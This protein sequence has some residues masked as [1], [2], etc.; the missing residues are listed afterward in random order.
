M[1]LNAD[2]NIQNKDGKTASFMAAQQG[3]AHVLKKLKSK[4]NFQ[5]AE[6]IEG[7]TPL[8][9]AALG[10]HSECVRELISAGVDVSSLNL[11]G[12]TALQVAEESKNHDVAN[13]LFELMQHT[14]SDCAPDP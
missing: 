2:P 8:H 10:G 5:I 12:K 14:I 3:H 9:A 6:S 1:D 13:L 7:A 4:A 11:K